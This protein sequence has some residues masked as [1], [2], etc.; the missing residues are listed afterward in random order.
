MLLLLLLPP[1][2]YNPHSSCCCSKHFHFC[3]HKYGVVVIVLNEAALVS[4]NCFPYE[5]L[6]DNLQLHDDDDAATQTQKTIFY[7]PFVVGS[8]HMHVLVIIFLLLLRH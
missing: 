6:H 4:I 3:L 5:R 8:Y 2:Q 7:Q 1:S